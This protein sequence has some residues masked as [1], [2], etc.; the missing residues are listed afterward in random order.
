MR[1]IIIIFFYSI[2]RVFTVYYVTKK[3]DV[4]N[5]IMTCIVRRKNWLNVE[6]IIVYTKNKKNNRLYRII[7][8]VNNINVCYETVEMITNKFNLKYCIKSWNHYGS[9]KI[10]RTL[11]CSL[12]AF[13]RLFDWISLCKFIN[14]FIHRNSKYRIIL[15]LNF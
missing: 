5:N 10:R 13:Q 1:I 12:S 8:H 4:Y 9:V 15:K 2:K 11:R 7:R 3:Y 6:I 14:D